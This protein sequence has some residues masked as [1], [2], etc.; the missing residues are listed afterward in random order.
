MPVSPGYFGIN[1][2]NFFTPQAA[3]ENP[4]SL[5][6]QA[7]AAAVPPF[8]G[9]D[10]V[11]RKEPV[12]LDGETAPMVFVCVGDQTPNERVYSGPSPVDLV[13]YNVAV[14][15]VTKGGKKAA[16]D[17]AVLDWRF[18]VN[19]LLNAPST[20]SG[21]DGLNEVTGTGKVPFPRSALKA[22][23]NYSVMA[24][25]VDVLEDRTY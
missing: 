14:V 22:D 8:E 12:L 23:L 10:V 19:N 7:L 13:K 6:G 16:V 17:D 15:L 20:Y 5:I 9:C 24:V 4:A 18:A 1:G 21:V 25:V 11:R 2:F 3:G